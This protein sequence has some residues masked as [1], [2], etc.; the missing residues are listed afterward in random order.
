MCPQCLFVMHF[1]RKLLCLIMQVFSMSNG[2]KTKSLALLNPLSFPSN[3]EKVVDRFLY[4]PLGLQHNHIFCSPTLGSDPTGLL[5]TDFLQVILLPNMTTSMCQFSRL[6]MY[7]QPAHS[8]LFLYLLS[9]FSSFSLFSS[10]YSGD[11]M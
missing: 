7:K 3:L 2:F 5:K 1:K 9:S 11:E 4:L 8:S 10:L 6:R